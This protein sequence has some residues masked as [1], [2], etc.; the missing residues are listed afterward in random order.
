MKKFAVLIILVGMALTF[1]VHWNDPSLLAKSRNGSVRFIAVDPDE[2]SLV[3][4]ITDDNGLRQVISY[5]W[6][7]KKWEEG[8]IMRRL[9]SGKLSNKASRF[10][11][12]CSNT[13][14]IRIY[15]EMEEL[16]EHK[17]LIVIWDCQSE[18]TG[19]GNLDSSWEIPKDTPRAPILLSTNPVT[20]G[21]DP[22]I[23]ENIMVFPTP[24]RFLGSDLNGDSDINDTILRY[25]NLVTGEVVNT[26][27]IVSGAHHA[28][29][30]YENIIVFVGEGSQI[31]YYDIRTGTVRNTGAT[32]SSPSI[33]GNIFTF[34]S[35]SGGTIHYFDLSTRM[36]VDT[37]VKGSSPFVY[38]S[39]IVFHAFTPN[40]TIWM[41]DLHTGIAV[42]T[43]VTG[44]HATLYETVIA[45]TTPEF[46]IAEDLNGDGDTNDWVIR[47]YN[48][49]TQTITN[50]KAVGR[51]PVF[52]GDRIVFTTP[53]KAV[54]QDFNGD[55]NILGSV[56]RYYDLKTGKVVNTQQLGTEPDIYKDTITFYLWERW[57]DQDLNCDGDLSDPIVKT[58]QISVTRMGIV[59]PEIWLFLALLV[60][61]SITAYFKKR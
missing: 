44:R 8:L 58:Y 3:Y 39:T 40:L 25:Q 57:T 10:I 7:G 21:G 41:Y 51:Y 46:S 23:Y 28:V 24:E 45:F 53:E 54:N 32:G 9:S 29:D 19:K 35:K 15:I 34:D 6:D 20:T 50:I 11:F 13:K 17:H 12:D 18:K 56:I 16:A 5:C 59:G 60:I 43:G 4:D 48:L 1:S 26:G 33:F 61:S 47:Y 42:N 38:Q 52:L 2:D 55:G 31:Y 30:I 37:K 36:L 27:L 49:E 22:P 14:T